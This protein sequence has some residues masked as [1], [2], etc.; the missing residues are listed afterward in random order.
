MSVSDWV[1]AVRQAERLYDEKR[2]DEA[3]AQA[4]RAVQGCDP[5]PWSCSCGCR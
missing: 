5:I 3:T 4:E 1:E 2:L